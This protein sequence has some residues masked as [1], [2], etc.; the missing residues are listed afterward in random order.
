MALTSMTALLYAAR[1][2]GYAVGYFEAWDPYSLEAVLRAAELERAPVILGFGCLLVD[3][4]WLDRGGIEQLG[5]V[6]RTVAERAEV[7]VALL[8][9]ESRTLDHALRG[10]EAGF[11]GVMLCTDDPETTAELVERA[12]AQGATV[13]AELGHLPDGDSSGRVDASSADLT[14]PATAEEFV[15]S[16]GV[17]CL[18]V[19]IGNV[20]TLETKTANPDLERLEAIRDRVDVPLV[21]HGGTGFPADAV[22]AAIERGVA[23]FNVG[24]ALKRAYLDAVRTAIDAATPQMSPHDVLGSHTSS[25]ILEAGG[26]LMIGVVRSYIRAYG[27]TDKAFHA[28]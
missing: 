1:D 4:G 19:S 22:P 11:N 21:I 13:E 5:A 9:N 24:T 14:D 18:A 16:T 23:K 20:H 7:P 3:Q 10:L 25:D 6:G 27:S 28:S 8:L 15:A 26:A 17:D 12:H 2:G